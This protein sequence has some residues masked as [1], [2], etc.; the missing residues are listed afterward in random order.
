MILYDNISN[1][2][3]DKILIIIMITFLLMVTAKHQYNNNSNNCN[4]Y[5]LQRLPR[6]NRQ[7]L[8]EFNVMQVENN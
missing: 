8:V 2:I 3:Y 5:L 4:H 1:A 7:I 6:N